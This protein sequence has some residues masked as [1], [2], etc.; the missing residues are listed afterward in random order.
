[1]DLRR[2]RRSR[3]S[4][5]STRSKLY[6]VY[7]AEVC[8]NNINP[9]T[10]RGVNYDRGL[11]IHCYTVLPGPITPPAGRT[12]QGKND[13][14]LGGKGGAGPQ[15]PGPSR[16]MDRRVPDAAGSWTA[17]S[18]TGPQGPGSSWIMDRRGPDPAGSWSAGSRI[19]PDHGPQ[20]PGPSR[21][22][23]RCNHKIKQARKHAPHSTV[24]GSA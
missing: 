6:S 17:G 19:Q 12:N 21:I 15:G 10:D 3:R 4:T 18:Q 11:N 22:M 9:R 5:R 1:M 16:I 23:D 2:V 14:S 20:G 13:R 24:E 8:K 7:S